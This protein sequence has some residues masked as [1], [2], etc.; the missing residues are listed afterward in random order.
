MEK[1]LYYVVVF[2]ALGLLA[3]LADASSAPAPLS[4]SKQQAD[5]V[6]GRKGRELRAEDYLS[7]DRH[8]HEVKHK[9]QLQPQVAAMAEAAMKRTAAASTKKAAGWKD[10]DDDGASGVGLID[11]ADYSGV[12]M[13]TPSA[14]AEAPPKHKHP[15]KP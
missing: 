3:S 2:F 9:E 5:H 14:S 15:N 11:S 4:M 13:H 6:L 1:L 7:G 12:A 8:R 10:E